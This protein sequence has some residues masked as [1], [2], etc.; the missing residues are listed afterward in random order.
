MGRA[1]ILVALALSGCA[2]HAPYAP[3]EVPLPAVYRAGA[4]SLDSAAALSRWWTAFE[5]PVLTALVEVA[6][7]DNLD[8]EAAAARLAAAS[9]S[10]RRARAALLPSGSIGGSAGVERQSLEDPIARL[11]SQFPGFERT[12]EQYGLEAGMSWEVDLFG[13]LRAGRRGAQAEAASA[14]AGVAGARLT[15]AAEVANTYFT[16]R[17]LERRIAVV[18]ARIATLTALER[19]VQLR[20]ARGVAARYEADQ[21]EGERAGA[22]A[23]LPQLQAGRAAA[24]NRL[25]VLLGRAPGSAASPP[26]GGPPTVP[27]Q[28][29]LEAPASLL[30]RRPD[31]VAAER[32]IAAADARISEAIA[33]YYPRLTLGALIGV[34][35]GDVSSL[36]GEDTLRLAGSAGFSGRLFDFGLVD[37]EVDRAR[38]GTREAV[39]LYR[40]AVFR[41]VAEVED[42]MTALERRRAQARELEAAE[43]ALRR[44]RDASYRAYEAGA[45][46]LIDALEAERRLQDVQ[47][48]LASAQAEAARAAVA[49]YRALGGGWDYASP[50]AA[51]PAPKSAR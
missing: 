50:E 40:Q 10:A 5:D 45:V 25:D 24:L 14:A 49:S 16:M 22:L 23:A 11:S 9:A 7:Q 48:N 13:R 18:E 37:A 28:V 19:L 20:L 35:S 6:L 31:L 4:D 33:A 39:A 8:L 38:A 44:A 32:S 1:A 29:A 36:L 2:T 30:R 43:A 41:A 12:A 21:A 46:S 26:P 34:L 3:P 47:E 17:E 27:A 42:G 51:Q 15:V